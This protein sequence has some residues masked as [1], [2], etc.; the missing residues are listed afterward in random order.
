MSL[1]ESEGIA[2]VKRTASPRAVLVG[3]QAIAVWARYFGVQ[4][5]VAALTRDVD[6][7]GSAMDA[8]R[9]SANIA[10]AHSLS[11]AGLD[12][13]TPNTAV[14][15]IQLAGHE[16]PVLI[17]YLADIA[18]P[19]AAEIQRTA[20]SIQAEG[21]TL[22]I[23]HPLLLLQSKMTNLQRFESKRTPEGIE[24]ARLAICVAAKYIETLVAGQTA[25]REIL[26]AVQ[27]VAKFAATAPAQY[28][29]VEFSL[30]CLE[31]IP[32]SVF[33]KDVL[34]AKFHQES[35]PRLMRAARAVRA[36]GLPEPGA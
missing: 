33:E 28:A 6:Y 27:S 36:R 8:K 19:T 30:D 7:L 11:V 2:L 14:I 31:A 24:Q 29:R 1:S 23:I 32:T 16:D 35:W 21:A 4:S 15:A 13:G 18:G 34:P 10:F 3:G 25:R 26:R 5:H 20:T 22:K 9:A 12:D 17:D